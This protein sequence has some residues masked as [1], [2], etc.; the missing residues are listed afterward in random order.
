MI[1]ASRARMAGGKGLTDDEM[2]AYVTLLGSTGAESL[3][4]SRDGRLTLHGG[5]SQTGQPAE[6]V[7]IKDGQTISLRTGSVIDSVSSS[8]GAKRAMDEDS[9]EDPLRSM[10]RRRKSAQAAV[11]E[12]QQCQDCDKV[13][14]RPCD[15]T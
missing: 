6:L 1:T 7:R 11:K 12:V 14:K 8:L 5:L 13:F 4:V 3:H 15:L 2:N 10:A 9:E